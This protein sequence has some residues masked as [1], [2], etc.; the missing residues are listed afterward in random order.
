M[1][2]IRQ[3]SDARE[4]LLKFW[5]VQI[6]AQVLN[7]IRSHDSIILQHFLRFSNMFLSYLT[8]L[9]FPSKHVNRL[10]VMKMASAFSK[11]LDFTLFVAEAC[12]APDKLFE[13]YNIRAP[14]AYKE[15]GYTRM[16]P[17]RF[18]QARKFLSHIRMANKETLWYTRDVLLCEWLLYFSKRFRNNYFFE[19]HT[20][21]R[22]SEGRY[23]N[24]LSNARGIITTNEA[25]KKD[26][27]EQFG[28]AGE[29]IFV[30]PNGVDLEEF[31]MLKDKKQEMRRELGLDE[32]IPLVVYAGTDAPDYGTDV[33]REAAK[34]LRNNAKVLIISRRPRNE[35]LKYMAAAD[36]LVAPY[37]GESEHFRKYMSPMKLREYM[38]MER[39]IVVS[40]LPSI[41]N[42]LVEEAA[43]YC[44]A[45]NARYLAEKI[46]MALDDLEEGKRRAR[47]AALYAE[48]FSWDNR[49]ENIIQFMQSTL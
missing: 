24:V 42:Y 10:Q 19:L 4:R 15:V 30:S 38:A 14:F 6:A 32:H 20:L 33:L 12:M 35:A 22:F 8:P 11:K 21:V 27:M 1:R 44:K 31:Q 26:I 49:A 7:F 29:K 28:I 9:T 45:G 5:I 40:D 16:L 3:G 47:R 46:T 36:V 18:W 2:E 37:L 34:L 25:K 43:F 48:N 39:P 17:R 41:R 23:K 13:A